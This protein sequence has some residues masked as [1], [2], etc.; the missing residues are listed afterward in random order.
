MKAISLEDVFAKPTTDISSLRALVRRNR[1]MSELRHAIGEVEFDTAYDFLRSTAIEMVGSG[2]IDRAIRG[3]EEI[4]ALITRSGENDHHLLDIHAA[5]MQ[6]LTALF[7]EKD[8][9]ESA[10]SSAASTLTLLSQEAKRKDEPFLQILGAL[11]YDIA[12]LHTRRKEYKQAERELSKALKIYERLAKTNP[13]R[14]ATPHVMALNATTATYRNRVKQAELLAHYQVAT[15]T[16]LQ[17]VNSGV[18]EA[19]GRLVDSIKSEGDTLA[20]MG[21]HREAMQYYTRALKYLTKIEPEFTLKQLQL[22]I[23]LGE[24]MLRVNAMKEKGIHLLNTML[25][26]ATKINATEEHRQIVDILFN[27][28]SSSLD[29]LGLWHKVFPK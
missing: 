14:Y 16:Y 20:Q 27:A 17:L 18:S 12:F 8:D 5:L 1:S 6:I 7:I 22:S 3:L 29:I 28:R 9:M 13:E 4:D 10:M 21:R 23:S 15:S 11:L 2:E 19:T 26:K 25:H 24:A